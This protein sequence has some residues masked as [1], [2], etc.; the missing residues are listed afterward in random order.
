MKV[1]QKNAI[2]YSYRKKR[3]EKL[4]AARLLEEFY[5]YNTGKRYLCITNYSKHIKREV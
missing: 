5:K 3:L 1:S 2:Y 4:K